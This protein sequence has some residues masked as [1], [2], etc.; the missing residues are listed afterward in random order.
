LRY[1]TIGAAYAQRRR[2]DPR[3]ASAIEAFVGRGV[4]VVDVGSGTG[5]YEPGGCAV[6]AVEPSWTMI[7]QRRAGAAP[8]VRGV[9]EALPFPE[10][11]FD[12]AM[13]VLSVHHWTDPAQGLAELRRV[14]ARQVV[15]YFEASF[16]DT[17]WIMDYWPEIT[18]LP[19]ERDPPGE[20]LFREHLDVHE[21]V[22]VPVPRD[23]ADG[24]AGAYWARPECYL[25]ETVRRGMSCFAQ[26]GSG[27]V[28]R[29]A[30]RLRADLRS[31]DW[32]ARFA[33]LRE[34]DE[35]DLG[36]RL[37]RAGA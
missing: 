1:D 20:R 29:G 14:S 15:L 28:E 25:D 10:G 35:L 36:Y 22:A 37:L 16:T 4:R 24:F 3:V 32:D 12:V 34:L 11:A 6:V 27:A 8:S 13:T 7:A 18:E 30:E 31:G 21:V 33:D 19:T 26:L 5:N 23:C 2:T 17:L 9:A